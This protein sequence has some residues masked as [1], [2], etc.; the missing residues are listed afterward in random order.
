MSFE[1]VK[2]GLSAIDPERAVRICEMLEA[3]KAEFLS[4]RSVEVQTEHELH[5]ID[6]RSHPSSETPEDIEHKPA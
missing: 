6:C 4:L 1:T 5:L 3:L 2:T